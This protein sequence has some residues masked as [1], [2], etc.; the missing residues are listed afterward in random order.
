M[1]WPGV[2]AALFATVMTP[3]A[4]SMANAPEVFP[5]TMAYVNTPFSGSVAA[6]VPTTVPLG[7]FGR[8][9]KEYGALANDGGTLMLYRRQ[10]AARDDGRTGDVGPAP[11]DLQEV[12]AVALL[13]QRLDVIGLSGRQV[14]GGGG[15]RGLR[16]VN[17]GARI[18]R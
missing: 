7:E 14:K 3:V 9:E 10:H 6:R 4:G 12:P 5:E 18:T 17:T 13:L 1:V 8:S 11:G 16:G 2:T 15:L